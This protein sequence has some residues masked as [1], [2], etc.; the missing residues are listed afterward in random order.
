MVTLLFQLELRHGVTA[1]GHR[2]S[3]W[4]DA[5]VLELDSGDDSLTL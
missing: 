2:V 1:N 3:F 5:N 4:C